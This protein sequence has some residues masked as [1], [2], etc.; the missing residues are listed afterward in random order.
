MPKMFLSLLA[1]TMM[2]AGQAFAGDLLSD[3]QM[4][5]VTA[6]ADITW[7]VSATAALDATTNA[8]HNVTDTLSAAT[9]VTAEADT[10]LAASAISTNTGSIVNK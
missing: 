7:D 10:S 8:D 2:L 3:S 1:G 9:D 6:G 5:T 4:D